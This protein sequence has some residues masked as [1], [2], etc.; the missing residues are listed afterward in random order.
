MKKTKP[1]NSISK[2]TTFVNGYNKGQADFIQNTVGFTKES[3]D[4]IIEIVKTNDIQN[5]TELLNK[6]YVI[7]NK[8][9]LR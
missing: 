6:Q 3:V 5:A 2:L 9:K 8:T 7:I 1:Y 4:Q